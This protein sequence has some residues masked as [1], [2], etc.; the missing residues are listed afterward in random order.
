MAWDKTLLP[1]TR[2]EIHKALKD[3]LSSF[4]DEA[5]LENI[6]E[7]HDALLAEKLQSTLV[8]GKKALDVLSVF[9]DTSR[10]FSE[11]L[12]P[13]YVWI[14]IFSVDSQGQREW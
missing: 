2:G 11:S 8:A 3:S 12:V 5:E 13:D 14:S 9:W 4:A 6:S 7:R 1:H 10:L